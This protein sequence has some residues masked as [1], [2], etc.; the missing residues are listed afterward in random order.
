M[1]FDHE[2]GG[3]RHHHQSPL[4]HR[5]DGQSSAGDALE[6]EE[7]ADGG[8]GSISAGPQLEVDGPASCDQSGTDDQSKGWSRSF[9]MRVPPVRRSRPAAPS[10]R[11]GSQGRALPSSGVRVSGHAR[12][13][14][15]P[16]K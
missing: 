2:S 1:V 15:G 4:R 13:A 7:R 10:R 6:Q 8:Y 12:P 3:R 5:G 16:R 9:G 14:H 11:H